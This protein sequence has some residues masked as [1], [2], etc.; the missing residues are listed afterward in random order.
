MLRKLLKIEA[1]EGRSASDK[2]E[3][4]S[5]GLS[6]RAYATLKT[7]GLLD[8]AAEQPAAQV[9]PNV[10]APNATEHAA[11]KDMQSQQFAVPDHGW[12]DGGGRWTEDRKGR[13]RV[14]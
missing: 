1:D 7:A 6:R 8:R 13:R 3:A 5:L 9:E 4:A 10:A 14:A 2:A 12:V 11:E